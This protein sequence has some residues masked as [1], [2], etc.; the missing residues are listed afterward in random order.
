MPGPTSITLILEEL[1]GGDAS[2]LDRLIPLVYPELRRLA[3]SFL[4][5]ERDNHTLQP[6]ALVHEAYVRLIEQDHPD[7]RNRAH[8]L[9]VAGHL[10]R[11]ILI[12]YARARNADKRGGGVA[13]YSLDEIYDT[14][15]ERPVTLIAVDDAL[16][17]LERK[18][19]RKAK[20]IEMRFFAG[21]THEET[22]EVVDSTVDKVRADLRLAQAWLQRELSRAAARDTSSK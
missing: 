17:A 4:R 15:V 11:Q 21:M 8:F 5:R 20:L 18:D 19:A 9:G 13:N 14:P 22:A 16:Q 7:F 1:S 10:M 3:D 6:T 2:A 12:D